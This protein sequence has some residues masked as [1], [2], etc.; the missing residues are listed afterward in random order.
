MK[1]AIIGG[2]PQDYAAL[3]QKLNELIEES[4]NYL[5]YVL[6][7]GLASQPHRTSLGEIWAENNGAPIQYIERDTVQALQDALTA[8]AD[9]IIFI[10]RDEQWIKNLIMKFRMTGKHGSVIKF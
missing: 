9:F 1:I 8:A 10:L 2:S 5:F 7:G 6:C 4:G 3:D